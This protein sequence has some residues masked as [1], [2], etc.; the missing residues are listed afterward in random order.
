MSETEI[1]TLVQ[2]YV[3][4]IFQDGA[5]RLG[6]PVISIEDGDAGRLNRAA[7]DLEEI[8]AH[9]VQRHAR[10]PQGSKRH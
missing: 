9:F 2:H 3:C 10:Q 8:L 6:V 5:R 7:A 4:R 1:N